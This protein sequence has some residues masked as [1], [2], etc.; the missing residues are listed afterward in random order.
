M[1]LLTTPSFTE[2]FDD[3]FE[4]TLTRSAYARFNDLNDPLRC[5]LFSLIARELIRVFLVRVAPDIDVASTKWFDPSINN[6]S[7]TRADRLR[8]ALTGRIADEVV[9]DHESLNVGNL[10]REL[11]IIIDEL[12][13]YTHISPETMNLG[14][15]TANAYLADVE[16]VII[17]FCNKYYEVRSYIK[18]KV[19]EITQGEINDKLQ[20]ELPEELDEL[21]SHTAF[22]C[23]VVE[24]VEDI[25]ISSTSMS[26]SGRGYVE[27]EL[28][29][30]S[31]EDG[32]SSDDHYPFS[33]EAEID[34]STL[35]VGEIKTDVDTSSFYE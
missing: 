31:G 10:C 27:V 17:L 7:P 2:L 24:E 14:I 11:L 15:A 18:D 22:Q 20:D 33:F 8:Y 1:R 16:D 19:Y 13:K 5:N 6:G 30:G 3:A 9:D 23:A 21:S 32:V 35:T 12:S 25:N 26:I 29:Y 28:N 34:P 4:Q